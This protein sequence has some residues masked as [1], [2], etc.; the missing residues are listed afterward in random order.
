MNVVSVIVIMMS[1]LPV[2]LSQ[3]KVLQ[4]RWGQ[5]VM[6]RTPFTDI[7]RTKSNKVTHH[8]YIFCE[9]ASAIYLC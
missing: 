9:L 2:T 3:N 5:Q 1:L 6:Y 7:T 4:R 8:Y